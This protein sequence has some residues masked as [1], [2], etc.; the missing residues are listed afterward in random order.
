VP[1]WSS[2][3]PDSS[4]EAESFELSL[5]SF[6]NQLERFRPTTPTKDSESD[7]EALFY[8][9]SSLPRPLLIFDQFEEFITLFDEAQRAGPTTGARRAQQQAPGVQKAILATL[10]KLIQDETL[11][12]RILFVFR[13][14]YLAKLG[15]LFKLCPNLLDQ[16][17]R[18]LTP[19][20][21]EV[22]RII[23]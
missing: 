20:V 17:Q 15:L 22:P 19:N 14:D 3:E 6:T 9:S 7:H 4:N 1:D 23:R 13:D 18:L 16:G 10:V 12:L 11:P 2:S 8:E 21:S 5:S